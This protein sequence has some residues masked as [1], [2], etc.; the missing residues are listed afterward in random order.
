MHRQLTTAWMVVVVLIS[1][2]RRLDGCTCTGPGPRR[3][4]ELAAVVF[5]GK[6]IGFNEGNDTAIFEVYD[7]WKGI[8]PWRT[9]I[10]VRPDYSGCSVFLTQDGEYLL[11]AS[12]GEDR[13][14]VTATCFPSR[15]LAEAAT[16]LRELGRP[17]WR[18][19]HH[20]KVIPNAPERRYWIASIGSQRQLLQYHWTDAKL[21]VH[22]R[23]S[24]EKWWRRLTLQVERTATAKSA[25]P[26]LTF[27]R[28]TAVC[29]LRAVNGHARRVESLRS[30]GSSWNLACG[31]VILQD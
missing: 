28:W 7:S 5:T 8:S 18:W 3:A 6:V 30:R 4:L 31:T 16:D 22:G 9:R 17:R 29:A 23:E 2:S 14:L 24:R 13:K 1:C 27:E 21:G 25:V 10:E 12:K 11:Y 26:P 15:P 19:W 20:R